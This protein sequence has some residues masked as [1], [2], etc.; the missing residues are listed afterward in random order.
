V[1]A[2]LLVVDGRAGVGGGDRRVAA[3]VAAAGAPCVT[4]VNKVDGMDAGAIAAAIDAAAGLCPFVSL[5]PVSAR[6]GDGVDALRDDLAA[7]LPEGP[8]FFPVGTV[9]DQ[10]E[11]GRIAEAVREAALAEVR[12]EVPHALAA[13][14]EEIDRGGRPPALVRVRL[15]CETESQKAILIGRRG[16]MVKR[17]GSAARPRIE[18]IV[19]G[20]VYLELSVKARPHWRR[21]ATALDDLGV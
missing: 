13:Q 3:R 7:L 6:T 16:S 12:E 18:R 20:P 17:I 9:S 2:V 11:E 10:T 19:G 4:V 8:A 5:H 1:D 21:D 14:V 15:I